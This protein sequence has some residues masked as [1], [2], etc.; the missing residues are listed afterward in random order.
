MPNCFFIF[1]TDPSNP[2]S[3][4]VA[5]L[6]ERIAVSLRLP[7]ADAATIRQ[8]ALLHDI[9]LV[10]VPS[11]VLHKPKSRLADA[12]WETLRLHPYYSQ[13]ILARVPA[14]GAAR[15]LV[16]SHHERP[17][18]EGYPR[19]VRGEQSERWTIFST[20]TPDLSCAR[21]FVRAVER[22]EICPI[23]LRWSSPDSLLVSI[24][25]MLEWQ[26]DLGATP[27]RW[28]SPLAWP[29]RCWGTGKIRLKGK[30]P[31]GQWFQANPRQMWLVTDSR[32]VIGGEDAGPP[33]PLAAQTFDA[34][35]HWRADAIR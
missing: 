12:E 14:F 9:G 27:P 8:A 4:R 6:S 3:R 16:A 20:T 10:A 22:T 32:G 24:P 31:N 13:R 33:A 18:G 25:D 15:E 19:G 5:D 11:F 30:V 34:S 17:D 28:P 2:H 29:S 7:P 35:R 26:V 21:Y 23:E 1:L